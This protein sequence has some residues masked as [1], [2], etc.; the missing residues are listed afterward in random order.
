MWMASE[1]ALMNIALQ[2]ACQ[3]PRSTVHASGL[4][5]WPFVGPRAAK[6]HRQELGGEPRAGA[7]G[8]QPAGN[9]GGGGAATSPRTHQRA[10]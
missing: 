7:D 4:I 6:M 1:I 3:C 9:I 8:R 10:S 5:R 2:Q